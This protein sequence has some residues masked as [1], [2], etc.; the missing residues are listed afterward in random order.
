MFLLISL[1]VIDEVSYDKF[2]S[3]ADRIYRM[4]FSGNIN[5]SEFV[6][7]L[8]S[9]PSGPTMPKEFPEV[10]EAIRFRSSGNWT[11]RRK[12]ETNA[13]NEENVVFVDKNF[14]TFWDFN[15]IKGDQPPV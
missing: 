15:L 3:D 12:E 5:G 6:T 9:A 11:I 2:H 8:A 4:D 13:Y 10:E 1:Y 14:F 7:A